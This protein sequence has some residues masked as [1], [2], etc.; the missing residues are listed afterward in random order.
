MH[1]I[2][3][4]MFRFNRNIP[5]IR[6]QLVETLTPVLFN[7]FGCVGL[8]SYFSDIHGL[9]TKLDLTNDARTT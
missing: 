6:Q 5:P 2:Y 9:A 3:K 8:C 4:W 7:S 1:R